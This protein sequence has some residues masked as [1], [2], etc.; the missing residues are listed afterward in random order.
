MCRNGQGGGGVG[1][2]GGGGGEG[3]GSLPGSQVSHVTVPESLE[4]FPSLHFSHSAMPGFLYNRN[5][6][7]GNEIHRND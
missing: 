2:G 4:Y 7:H 5:E 1:G 3:G 6:I